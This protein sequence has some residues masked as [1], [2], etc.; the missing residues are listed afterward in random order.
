MPLAFDSINHGKIAFGFFNI[1]T[2]MLLLENY[3]IFATQFCNNLRKIACEKNSGG[4]QTRWEVDCIQDASEI[5][6]LMGAI[7][8]VQYTGFIGETYRCFPFPSDP[9]AFKQQTDG[10]KNQAVI[11]EMISK[12]AQRIEIPFLADEK[13]EIISIGDYQFTR[14]IWHKLIVY[15]WRGGFP[16]WH[17]EKMPDY[18]LSMKQ[19]IT[20]S[21]HPLFKGLRLATKIYD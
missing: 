8:G 6:D 13:A 5:G 9:E 19:S 4:I 20:E 3:F 16:R 7:H 10:F 21:L 11:R 18:V 2:D 12:Y 15:V 17:D 1:E 14:K